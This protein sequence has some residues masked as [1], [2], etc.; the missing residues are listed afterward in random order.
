[1]HCS[2]GRGGL[3]LSLSA[4][5]AALLA[6]CGGGN[7]GSDGPTEGPAAAKAAAAADIAIPARASNDGVRA[8]ST[9]VDGEKKVSK[10]PA[11]RLYIVQLAEA[12]VAGYKGG[13]GRYAATKPARG[14]K[15]DSTNAAVQS[16]VGYLQSR[17][18]AVL[19]GVG[20]AGK[21]SYSYSYTFNGFAAE[22]SEAQVAKLA[23]T[24]G[25]LGVVKDEAR[26]LTTSTT[27]TFL[28]LTGAGGFYNT[29]GKSGEGIVIGI[30]D[31]GI[32]PEHPSF[33]AGSGTGGGKGAERGYQKPKGWHGL[34]QAG[35]QFTVAN[36]NGKLIG[37]RYYNAALGGNEVVQKFLPW[38]FLSPRDFNGHGTHTAS[39]AG[40]NA[41]VPTT[42]DAAVFGHISGIAPRAQIAAYKACWHVDGDGSCFSSDSV[43]AIDQA[44]AD[45]VDV[46][47]FSIGGT[48][49]NFLDPVEV[50]FLFAADAGVFVASSAG[51]DG[52]GAS[53]VAK[54]GPWLTTVAAG[55]HDRDGTGSVTLGNGATYTGGSLANALASRPLV[56]AAAAPAAGAS[57]ADA[58]LCVPGTLDPATVSGKIVLCKRGGIALV[59]KTA[60]VKQAG[61][62]GA[63]IYNAPG[64]ASNTFALMHTVPT[65]HVVT[66]SGAA[67]KAYIAAGGS[68]TASIAKADLITVP[69]PFTAGFSSRGPILAG[70]GDLLKPDIIAPGQ[71]IMAGVAPPGHGGVLF[72]LL[73]G[74]SMSTPHVAGLAALMKELH[75]TWSPMAIKSALMTTA[76]DVLDGPNTD[77]LVIFSQGAGHVRPMFARDPGL[78]FDNGFNEWLAFLCGTGQ[79]VSSGCAAIR[80]DPSD[81][82]V[83]SIAIGDLAGTQTVTRKVTN[84][85]GSPATYTALV[86]GMNGFDVQVQPPSLVVPA[87]GTATF[88]V[89]FTRTGAAPNVYTGGQLTL[90]DGVHNVRLPMVVRPVALAAPPEVAAKVGGTSYDVV[91]GY[92]GAFSAT[93][94]GLIAST[95]TADTVSD[96]PTNGSCTLAAPNA[97][98]YEVAVPAGTTLA[99]FAL[100]D[101]EV[102][103][104]S[105][106]DLCVFLGT[107]L[108]GT[109]T[110]A[111][112]AETVSLVN[113]EAGTYT[114]VVHGWE[115]GGGTPFKL[116]QW[117]LGSSAAG[118]MSVSAPSSATVGAKGTIALTFSG[119]EA[120][121]RYVGSVAYA[122]TDGMPDPTIVTIDPPAAP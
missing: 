76:G 90:S 45:G 40:G 121:K 6:A 99:R 95:I 66:A 3:A 114:V 54:P 89:A 105:D 65:V 27:P 1:M 15:I 110:T 68:P 79:L 82:N 56:D 46:I 85:T 34:C 47:N 9:K 115:V 72:D 32:W 78:V 84:V 103:A 18:D 31:S 13:I 108:V 49:T 107:E 102:N 8:G 29:T 55:T 86:S 104:G 41:D 61:G 17:H 60:A 91:F 120:G 113:P 88:T 71:D 52:P 42:G 101:A 69:A 59:D 112:S 12:P 36:C 35:E 10:V 119:L 118:N 77:P 51:N 64:G 93:A 26:K 74:T 57:A 63:V 58:E 80:I 87:N 11:S 21:K 83:P 43:A 50:A 23:A 81:L 7:T 4:L 16:Y 116:H 62:S 22:L 24:P 48:S 39:T 96:D 106:I 70:G 38:E 75:P 109:S 94:R 117:L 2:R 97:K 28:G 20:A 122:G 53:T 111:T 33:A 73:S 14:N 19:A 5:A 25:V 67:I 44:V 92:T 30:V 100:F 98:K 37:A